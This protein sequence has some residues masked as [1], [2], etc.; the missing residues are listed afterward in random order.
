MALPEPLR[1]AAGLM[2]LAL[3]LVLLPL[4]IPLGLACLAGAALLLRRD[5]ARPRRKRPA[6]PYTNSG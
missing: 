3:G 1:R 2:L 5:P 6:T 4:P